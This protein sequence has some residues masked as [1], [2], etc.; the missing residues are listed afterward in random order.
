MRAIDAGYDE[1]AL[2]I[3]KDCDIR[4]GIDIASHRRLP[5]LIAL[6]EKKGNCKIKETL[7][8]LKSAY[9]YYSSYYLAGRIDLK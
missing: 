3:T 5:A 4:A 8:W 2:A 7:F 9:Y 1:T 6:S